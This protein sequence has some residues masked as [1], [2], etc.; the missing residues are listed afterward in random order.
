M[1]ETEQHAPN[2]R[3][4]SVI[5]GALSTFSMIA[6]MTGPI[7]Q[8]AGGVGLAASF[9][10]RTCYPGDR[11]DELSQIEA[12][13]NS[14]STDIRQ[15]MEDVAAQDRVIDCLS[16]INTYIT[17][18]KEQCEWVMDAQ[19]NSLQEE[20]FKQQLK[21]IKQYVIEA[22]GP[23]SAL[24]QAMSTLQQSYQSSVPFKSMALDVFALGASTHLHLE[25][26]R[27]LMT[28]D[29]TYNS[30]W[31]T[32]VVGYAKD[33]RK[34]IDTTVKDDIQKPFEERLGGIQPP[35]HAY[36]IKSTQWGTGEVP[37]TYVVDNKAAELPKQATFDPLP[38]DDS[39]LDP[40]QVK[41]WWPH[42]GLLG[43][44][45]PPSQCIVKSVK[46]ELQ[47]NDEYNFG[48][49]YVSKVDQELRSL[50]RYELPTPGS[51]YLASRHLQSISAKYSPASDMTGTA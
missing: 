1:S 16:K 11:G 26:C 22:C 44:G 34:H 43:R 25:V 7:G 36:Y 20:E 50:Y 47:D 51:Y 31:A 48:Y 30:P 21:Q 5:E 41:Y 4:L 19:A 42:D 12:A 10:L 37:I 9:L 15:D 40:G 18:N 27:S 39:F 3:T 45:T 38:E 23:N 46:K 6:M 28:S 49:E 14:L 33:Y 17:W 29:V 2:E 24:Q 35:G 13:V 8:I 32:T